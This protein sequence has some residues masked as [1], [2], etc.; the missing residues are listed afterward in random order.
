MIENPFKRVKQ[1]F[2][3]LFFIILFSGCSYKNIDG[4]NNFESL[5][6]KLVDKAVNKFD[7]TV[8]FNDVVLVADFVNIDKLKNRS[9]LGFLL[10]A[11]LKD[12]LLS[13]NILVKEIQLREQF[14]L[15][16]NGFNLLSRDVRD[17]QAKTTAK[18]AFIGTYSITTRRLIVFIKLIDIETGYILS[19]SQASTRVDD[20][21]LDLE[22]IEKKR[23]SIFS[24]L[25]L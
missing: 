4:S 15:G 5:V 23:P 25:V 6:N 19:S 1:L 18:H 3:L 12:R 21:I 14:T 24:P 7:S 9:Q 10:S 20:E 22:K 8:D 2:V 13:K 11:T 16:K 17:V